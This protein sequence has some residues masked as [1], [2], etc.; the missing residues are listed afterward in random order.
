MATASPGVYS[1]SAA[2]FFDAEGISFTVSPAVP[3]DGAAVGSTPTYT[4]V[5]LFVQTSE[6]TAVLTEANAI[7]APLSTLQQQTYT[8]M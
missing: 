2:P 6:A 7:N 8:F 5:R 1:T 4:T 3:A